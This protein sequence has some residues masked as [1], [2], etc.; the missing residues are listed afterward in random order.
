MR[1]GRSGTLYVPC[2]RRTVRAVCTRSSKMSFRLEP[3]EIS[4]L[5][6]ILWNLTRY[7]CMSPVTPSTRAVG[8]KGLCNVRL[9]V[10]CLILHQHSCCKDSRHISCTQGYVLTEMMLIIAYK[11]FRSSDKKRLCRKLCQPQKRPTSLQAV[12]LCTY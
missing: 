4:V 6:V 3:H 7:R 1:S 5:A 8:K 9:L 12:G 11:P 2:T 10:V